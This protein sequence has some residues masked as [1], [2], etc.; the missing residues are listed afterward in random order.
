MVNCFTYECE[1]LY[2]FVFISIVIWYLCFSLDKEWIIYNTNID[3]NDE[4]ELDQSFDDSDL[5]NKDSGELY[6]LLNIIKEDI[7]AQLKELNDKAVSLLKDEDA[8]SASENLKHWEQILENLT[9]EGR[10]VDRNQIIV[11]LHNLAWC[12]QR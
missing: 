12:Y 5:Q 7:Q 11:V 8:E 2:G 6:S 10:D 1:I 9:S 3:F 4:E